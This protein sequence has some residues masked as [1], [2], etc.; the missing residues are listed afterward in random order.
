M[1]H[2]NSRQVRILGPFESTTILTKV[3]T[4]KWE[5]GGS[6]LTGLVVAR[7]LTG[8]TPE[9]RGRAGA[10]VRWLC[11]Q[12]APSARGCGAAGNCDIG[13]HDLPDRLGV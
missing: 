12:L 10:V 13:C 11:R 8:P 3:L 6:S 7:R 4:E 5:Q 9:I 2:Q 1:I